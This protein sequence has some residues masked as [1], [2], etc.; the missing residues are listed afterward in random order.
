VLTKKLL[1]MSFLLVV[2]TPS[3]A[4][5]CK[6]KDAQN[7]TH[8][9][10]CQQQTSDST[11]LNIKSTPVTKPENA[12]N[13]QLD[14]ISQIA[15]AFEEDRLARQANKLAL[16]KEKARKKKIC[17]QNKNR[18]N[19]LMDDGFRFY[20]ED[21]D[22]NRSYL[23]NQALQ[24]QRE[25]SYIELRKD[26]GKTYVPERAKKY[27]KNY[28]SLQRKHVNT[29]RKWIEAKSTSPS[30]TSDLYLATHQAPGNSLSRQPSPPGHSAR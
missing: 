22:L 23:S 1:T 10:A 9:G 12:Q 2:S 21:E 28:K 27:A 24:M 19:Q 15:I 6:W 14:T 5:I 18:L 7:I 11:V 20:D 13:G 30:L 26:C 3:L 25:V 8:Y 29:K 4:A 17:T 16:K